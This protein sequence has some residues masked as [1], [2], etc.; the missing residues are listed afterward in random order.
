MISPIASP[1][2]Y[3]S[4]VL[5]EDARNGKRNKRQAS[6]QRT[7]LSKIH[8]TLC[9]CPSYKVIGT[10]NAKNSADY[11]YSKSAQSNLGTGPRH[12]AV[13]HVRRKLPIGYNGAPQMRPQSTPSRGPI[14]KPQYL[15]DPWTRPT[16]DAKRYPD[17]IRCFTT[18]HCSWTQTDRQSVR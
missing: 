13:A 2:L 17:P 10:E 11:L 3:S 1:T 14:A 16:Y 15:P 8:C 5:T 6:V 18:M 9:I 12:G 7:E 4:L